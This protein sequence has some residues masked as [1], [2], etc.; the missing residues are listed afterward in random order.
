MSP[1]GE[2]PRMTV[3]PRST[4]K[5]GS[6]PMNSLPSLTAS[7]S[8][9]ISFWNVYSIRAMEE[10]CRTASSASSFPADSRCFSSSG[11]GAKYWMMLSLPR[12]TMMRISSNPAAAASATT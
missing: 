3:S 6:L 10:T 4:A 7:P 11:F 5:T 9:R 8:P 12:L 1:S 2:P